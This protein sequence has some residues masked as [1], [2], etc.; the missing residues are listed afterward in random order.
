M[1]T[2]HVLNGAYGARDC[3]SMREVVERR[4]D[5]LTHD[6]ATLVSGV[7]DEA[8]PSVWPRARQA[9][10]CVWQAADVVPTMQQ[11]AGNAVESVRVAQE[12]TLFEPC[13]MR[14]VVR[15]DA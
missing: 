11:H 2:A 3:A 13:G 4:H 12:H 10:S 8:Q 5:P 1:Y 15:G 9:P 14:E 6:R 7:R